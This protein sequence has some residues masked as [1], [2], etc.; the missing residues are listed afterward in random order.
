MTET[1]KGGGALRVPHVDVADVRLKG[2]AVRAILSRLQPAARRREPTLSLLVNPLGT[3]VGR[4]FALKYALIAGALFAI[5]AFPF[6]LFGAKHDWL[7]SYLAGYAHLAGAALQV[8]EPE[9]TVTGALIAGRFPIEIVRNCDAIEVNILFV[10]AVLAFPAVW[11]RKALALAVGLPALVA[12]NVIRICLLYAIGVHAPTL[13]PVMHEQVFPLLL[14]LA[15]AL[16]FL[17]CASYFGRSPQP[18]GSRA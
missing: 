6:D 9:V 11:R 4:K 16:L 2:P 8:F 12:L 15:A 14:V 10:S 17:G 13:F 18:A 1:R 7:S 5:Y 3:G